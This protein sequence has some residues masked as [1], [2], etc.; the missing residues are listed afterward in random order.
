MAKK[1]LQIVAI[2]AAIALVGMVSLTVTA[3][4]GDSDSE[5]GLLRR[6]H[7]MVGQH[8][9][10]GGPHHQDHMGA[11]IEQMELTPDQRQRLEK[12]HEIAGT[13]G[14]EGH[15]SMA[16]AHR[17]LMSQFEQGYVDVDEVRGMIDGHLEQMRDVAYAVTDELIPLVNELDATQR[18]TLL[19]HLGGLQEAQHGHGHHRGHG[20]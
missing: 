16:E 14:S 7:Q 8:M 9:S 19:A 13:F 2:V 10:H 5:S 12:A 6:F 15:A 11:F 4:G 1:T 17:Q 18:E 3:T 20:H